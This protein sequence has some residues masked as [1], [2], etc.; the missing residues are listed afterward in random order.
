MEGKLSMFL[1]RRKMGSF[2]FAA[3]AATIAIAAAASGTAHSAT[4]VRHDGIH[5]RGGV[6][7]PGAQCYFPAEIK[8]G[9]RILS[10]K[11]PTVYA[12]DRTVY[13]DWNWIRF[14]THVVSTFTGA[15]LVTTPWSGWALAYDDAAAR[16]AG[17]QQVYLQ[18]TQSL[19]AIIGAAVSQI[20]IEWWT[21]TNRTGGATIQVSL[22]EVLAAPVR[23]DPVEA[24]E[25]KIVPV[26]Y[27]YNTGC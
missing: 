24:E 15:E 3:V 22:Y 23:I 5:G 25:D 14:R 18:E 19:D 11:P 6:T 20:E 2:R 8:H 12:T 26:V 7:E 4:L 21:Q 9:A 27:G 13:R 10:T 16:D 1:A 17:T